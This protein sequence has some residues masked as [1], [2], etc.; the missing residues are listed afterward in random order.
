ML[1]GGMGS[2]G[3][4]I[5]QWIENLSNSKL[6]RTPCRAEFDQKVVIGIHRPRK[7]VGEMVQMER[8]EQPDRPDHLHTN[9]LVIVF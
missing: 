5:A 6:D 2:E 4:C 7:W 1:E 3:H 8:I 9:F